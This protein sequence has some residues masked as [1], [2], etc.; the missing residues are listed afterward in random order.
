MAP[1]SL[2][3]GVFP[4]SLTSVW[5]GLTK[6]RTILKPGHGDY[7]CLA[8]TDAVRSA[9]LTGLWLSAHAMPNIALTCVGRICHPIHSKANQDSKE[10]CLFALR[11]P[12]PTL[13]PPRCY[14]V[15]VEKRLN[16]TRVNRPAKALVFPGINGIKKPIGSAKGDFAHPV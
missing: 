13:Q 6:G 2:L 16:R 12:V 3:G 11:R 4:Q 15:V 5:R 7:T 9:C 10:A 1:P 14:A 8:I